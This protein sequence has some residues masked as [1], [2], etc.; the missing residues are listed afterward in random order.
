[1]NEIT[2]LARNDCMPGNQTSCLFGDKGG[3]GKPFRGAG[4]AR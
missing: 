4:T 2:V 3:P 1:M